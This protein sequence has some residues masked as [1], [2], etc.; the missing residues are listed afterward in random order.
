MS[1]YKEELEREYKGYLRE[2]WNLSVNPFI[3]TP[4][5]LEKIPQVF[6]DR[7]EEMKQLL[8]DL[9]HNYPENVVV[10][11]PYGI[12][13]TIFLY[14]A[15]RE[16]R[17]DAQDLEVV[18]CV[19]D[20][21]TARDF[22]AAVLRVLSGAMQKYD[23]EALRVHQAI[24]GETHSEMQDA[25]G[26][27]SVGTSSWMPV[28][29][30]LSG[31]AGHST[32]VEYGPFQSAHYWTHTL[33]GRAVREHKKRLYIIVDEL[34]K[35]DPHGYQSLL[36]ACRPTLDLPCSFVVTGGQ[37]ARYVLNNPHSAVTGVAIDNIHLRPFDQETTR[38]VIL[39]Y[40][41]SARFDI[42]VELQNPFDDDAMVLIWKYTGGVPRLINQL[43]HRALELAC[44][45]Q[46]T[47]VT[48]RI[49]QDA[50]QRIG[51]ERFVDLTEDERVLVRTVS[52][53]GGILSDD[54]TKVLQALHITSVLEI[55]PKLDVLSKRDVLIK[56][57]E[58][59]RLA[60]RVSEAVMA[61]YLDAGQET[62]Y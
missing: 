42:S 24:R 1:T 6:T 4:P 58:H 12:G 37:F 26:G 41:S 2:V 47:V 15:M 49:V 11:G 31:E 46:L 18:Y 8:K 7:E 39:A 27:A 21:S 20:G 55:E 38:K 56:I 34:D 17:T 23:T 36:T 57:E 52:F 35:Q 50:L 43:C 32:G 60:Y 3:L 29:I 30:T 9:L 61:V 51:Q 14:E 33:I 62:I 13:K 44:T 16:L 53:H 48:V 19:L 59:K 40:L 22:D 10:Y 45:N 25:G 28:A 5:P 54:N